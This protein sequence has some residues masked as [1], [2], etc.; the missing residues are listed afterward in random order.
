VG[1]LIDTNVLSEMRKRERGNPHVHAWATRTR[2]NDLFLSVLVVGE[3]RC[4]IEGLRRRDPGQAAVLE[5]WLDTVVVSFGD[6]ILPITRSIAELWGRISVPD[7]LPLIDGL[8][9]ATALSHNLTLV[10]RDV[11]RSSVRLLNPFEPLPAS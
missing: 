3:L 6:R 9:A 1:F 2:T 5:G 4:G 11:A 10:T 7:R 8:L